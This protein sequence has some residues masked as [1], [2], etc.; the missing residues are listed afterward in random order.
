MI[1][2]EKEYLESKKRLEKEFESIEEH[3][4][5]MREAGMTDDQ[6]RLATDPLLS[7][8]FQLKEEVEEYE[9]LKSGR[10]DVLENLNGIGRM[11]V[12]L[13]VFKGIKQKDLAKKLG[14]T[15]AQVSRDER[16]EYYG[17]SVDKIQKVLTA[18]DVT[19]KSEIKTTYRDA[20]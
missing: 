14:V 3:Q 12:A 11:L 16:N 9:K 8:A 10:F 19:L 17:A 5:K 18:L 7:F 20:G 1:K 4:S 15:E 6:I 2:T 13:R